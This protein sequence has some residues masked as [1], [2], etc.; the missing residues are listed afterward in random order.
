MIGAMRDRINVDFVQKVSNGRGGWT[1]TLIDQGIFWG[2]IMDESARNQIQY[3]QA[4]MN[5]NTTIIMRANDKIN[6]HCVLYARGFKYTIEEIIVDER[7][8]YMTIK[9]VGERMN[10]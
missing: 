6:R 1:F 9:A 3:R 8:Q 7:A 2:E 10:G 5:T 4:D